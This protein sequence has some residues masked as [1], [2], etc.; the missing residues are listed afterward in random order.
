MKIANEEWD[1]RTRK[2]K[3]RGNT[4]LSK[5]GT[6]KIFSNLFYTG[7]FVYG[8]KEYI[9]K[10]EAMI[11]QEEYEKVQVLLGK[12]GNPRA[13]S[14]EFPYTGIIK[15]GYCG[16]MI[17][18]ERKTKFIKSTSKIKTYIYYHCTRHKKGYKCN[19]PS[20]TGEE[21]EKQIDKK[22]KNSTILPNLE[23]GH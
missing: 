20:I 6:Y 15:C 17:T 8:D 21:L 10:H 3:K 1:F 23:N 14:Y 7:S 19:Q 5:S 18:A 16:G 4:P 22:L 9:S 2:T 11:T 12:K 13:K